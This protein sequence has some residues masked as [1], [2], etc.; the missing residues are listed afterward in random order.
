M[1]VD[2]TDPTR[3]VT[4]TLDGPVLAVLAR[5]GRPVT[6]GEIATEVPRGS[7]IGIRR[8]VARLVEQGIVIATQ[9]GRNTVHELNREH[10]AAPAADI[11][12]NLWST[13]W[14]RLRDD[15]AG[16]EVPPVYGCVFGSAARRDGNAASDIDLLLVHPLRP[17]ET[18]PSDGRL[19]D[20]LH[21]VLVALSAKPTV[22]DT[23]GLWEEQVD[24][25]RSQV[26]RWT[27]NRLQVV[28]LSVP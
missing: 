24:Q 18:T 11:L 20:Q 3:A 19:I 13:L 25:L 9:M 8:A 5:A 17:G 2:L 21:G 12:S 28:D 6:V 27:G 14:G 23:S 7:E 15:L 26:H 1:I 4:S 10:L 16:W 22:S